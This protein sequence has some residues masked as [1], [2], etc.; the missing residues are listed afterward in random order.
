[1]LQKSLRRLVSALVALTW[2]LVETHGS[3]GQEGKTYF[4]M[5]DPGPYVL[6]KLGGRGVLEIS[7]GPRQNLLRIAFPPNTTASQVKR[8]L[9]TEFP[10]LQFVDN[11]DGPATR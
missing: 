11:I 6:E 2:V 9:K 3:R 8:D 5:L 10:D 1:M 7:A 4:Y